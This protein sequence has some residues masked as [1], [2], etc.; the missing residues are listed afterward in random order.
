MGPTL[1]LITV[2]IF[3]LMNIVICC[4]KHRCKIGVVKAEELF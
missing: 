4:I 2:A 1:L 3:E